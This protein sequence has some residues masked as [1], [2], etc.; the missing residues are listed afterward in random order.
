[1]SFVLLEASSGIFLFIVRPSKEV[2]T[3]DFLSSGAYLACILARVLH[4]GWW[5]INTDH[6]CLHFRRR[7]T[8]GKSSCVTESRAQLSGCRVS[9]N[10]TGAPSPGLLTPTTDV[11][12]ES[13]RGVPMSSVCREAQQAAEMLAALTHLRCE[14][15]PSMGMGTLEGDSSGVFTR[16]LSTCFIQRCCKKTP[17]K[18]EMN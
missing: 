10:T 13:P 3:V 12:G 7:G 5:L 15:G 18:D 17:N 16:H 2:E 4:C 11:L 8:D 1:M 6:T 14:W 9:L